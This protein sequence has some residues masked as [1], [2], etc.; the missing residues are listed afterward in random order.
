MGLLRL[1][2]SAGYS[3]AV[4]SL[5]SLSPR[6]NDDASRQA[7]GLAMAGLDISGSANDL[8]ASQN[9]EILSPAIASYP[10]RGWGLAD[11]FGSSTIDSALVLR[12]LKSAGKQAGLAVVKETLAASATSSPRGFNVPPGSSSLVLAVRSL[13][14][15]V[16]FTLTYPGGISYYLDL[17]TG[18]VP[19]SIAFPLTNG[20]L[21]FTVQNL[22]GTA[23]TYTAE[24]GFYDAGGFDTFRITTPLT[25]LGLAQNA[26]GGW[27]IG[28]GED[29]HLMITAEVAR[30]LAA[31]GGTFGPQQALL[32]AKAWLLARENADGGFSS[33][34][35]SSNIPET[36][37][38][39]LAILAIDPTT[40]L[41]GAA[42]YLRNAQKPNGSWGNNPFQTALTMQAIQ[43]RPVVSGIPGQSIVSPYAFAPVA[44]DSYVHDPDNSTNEMSW[45]VSGN[46]LL[47]V[48]ISNRIALISYVSS[49]NPSISEELVFVATDPNGLSG[50][51]SATFTVSSNRP[52]IVGPI[53][54]Q[55][56]GAPQAFAAINLD[57]Y[58]SDPDETPSQMSWTVTG[59][60]QLVVSVS[61]RV[62]RISYDT[63]T[64]GTISEQLTFRA[65]DVAG[66][67]GSATATFSVAPDQPPVVS[68]IPGQTV[69]AP[70]AFSP[71]N[72]DNYVADPDNPDNQIAWQVA[73]ASRVSVTLSNRVAYLTYAANP[74][75]NFTEQ[76][77]FIAADPVGK[78]ASNTTTFVVNSNRP[79]IVTGIPSQTVR[80]TN[81]FAPVILDNYVTDTSETAAQMVWQVTGTNKL[82]VT[83][84]NRVAFVSYPQNLNS[85]VSELLTFRATDPYGLF[86]SASALFTAS[87]NQPPVVSGIPGQSIYV[88]YAFAPINLDNYVNDPDDPAAQLSWQISG[89]TKLTATLSNH[90]AFIAYPLNTSSNLTE[91]LT[92]KATDPLGAFGT[93]TVGFTV[94]SNR[95]PV[96]SAI[97]GQTNLVPVPFAPIN[98]D[99]YVSDPGDSPTQMVWTVTGNTNLSVSISANRVATIT[100]NT[101]T[102]NSISE[103]LTFKATDPLGLFGTN[104]TRFAVTYIPPD[105]VI[106]RGGSITDNR[107]FSTSTNAWNAY[108][109]IETVITNNPAPAVTYTDLGSAD[110]P[111]NRVQMNYRLSAAG[112]AVLGTYPI[113]IEYKI[114]DANTNLLGPLTN[115]YFLFR[116]KVTQ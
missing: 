91:N 13:S 28:P 73:G 44:L 32:A 12:A 88:P 55:S 3:A 58:V 26:D 6:N 75:T 93:M 51:A 22:A 39:M 30:S 61:N 72:L 15:S 85:N 102:T 68:A 83:L 25:Y 38:A 57:N 66:L 1:T 7:I 110:L 40:P 59:N 77:T 99:N 31:W 52:P 82:S 89:G 78:M 2:D 70:Y 10:G 109:E 111:P 103:L 49:N 34:T 24:A 54:G 106:A 79:P 33:V 65:V 95:A 46:V 94:N 86:G 98:L 76:L 112:N 56:V 5:A 69:T 48:N 105:Y 17:T 62:A 29:S 71:I 107:I 14:G 96:V 92:F 113:S 64:S 81:A 8:L 63:N 87:S 9:L 45:S 11:G 18:Q 4:S 50:S 97:P 53:P 114:Y 47:S 42:N 35:N 21:T 116:V 84:S 36:G 67:S 23:A 90:V 37:L 60:T 19:T 101:Q 108:Q 104:S 100:Y 16:R 27:G 80:V 20:V 41:T 74:A 43:L 115:N